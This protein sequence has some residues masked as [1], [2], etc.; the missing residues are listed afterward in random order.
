MEQGKT[1]RKRLINFGLGL[2]YAIFLGGSFWLKFEPGERIGKSF[3]TFSR[4]MLMMM[5]LVFVLIGLFEVWVSRDTV[6]KHLG[7]GSGALGYFW[8]VVLAGTVM[9]PLYVA[10]PVAYALSHKGA[11]LGVVFTYIGAAAICRVPMT[12]FEATFLG[13]KFT[14]VRFLVSLPLVIMSSIVLEKFLVTTDYSLTEHE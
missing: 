3:F 9:G 4:T 11:R 2:G 10:L 7:A 12:A 6:E 1:S 8:A 5:P 13:V 14:A